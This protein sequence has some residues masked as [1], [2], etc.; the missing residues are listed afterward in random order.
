MF[1]AT[2]L[3]AGLRNP[4]HLSAKL[5]LNL[6][7]TGLIGLVA[8]ILFTWQIVSER[9]EVLEQR[10][11]KTNIARLEMLLEGQEHSLQARALGWS[12]W[13][14]A[15]DHIIDGNQAFV[16]EN[17]RVASLVNLHANSVSI[18]RFDGSLNN[19]R[20]V[21]LD[22]STG[23]IAKTA[24]L[25]AYVGSPQVRARARQEAK[26]QTFAR[27]GDK[28]V[29]LAFS[30]VLKIDA[31]DPAAGF[32]VIGQEIELHH[33]SEQ[34]Q[35]RSTYDFHVI[36]GANNVEIHDRMIKIAVSVADIAGK[37]LATFRFK[38]LR[39]VDAA[40]DDLLIIVGLGIAVL[41]LVMAWTLSWLL[42]QIVVK[43][44]VGI[45]KHVRQIG[46]SKELALLPPDDRRDEI[47]T[48]QGGFNAMA[49]QLMELRSELEAQSFELGKNQSA[50]GVMHNVRNGLSPLFTIISRLHEH[51]HF[52]EQENVRCA[53]AE[54]G[55]DQLAVH[56]R[57]KLANFLAAA[58]EYY[59]HQLDA[60]RTNTREAGRSLSSVL[61]AMEQVQTG[62]RASPEITD[63]D[64]S[65]LVA[66]SLFTV[67]HADGPPIEVEQLGEDP[68]HVVRAN[69]VLLSQIIVNL[70]TNATE[71]IAA[72]GRAEGKIVIAQSIIDGLDGP[73]LRVAFTDN[74]EGFK[75]ADATKLFE[76]GYSTRAGKTGGLGLHWCANTL[77]ATGGA[78]AMQSGG[79]GQG[80][81]A[82]LTLPLSTTG[83]G[84]ALA[85]DPLEAE[86]SAETPTCRNRRH[87]DH[88]SQT[89]PPRHSPPN[90]E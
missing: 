25:R 4:K 43:P 44:L 3:W 31:K 84:E 16:D 28:L 53:L 17:F 32:A 80:A 54:L 58:I 78:L 36:S 70:L 23:D 30:H 75:S 2:A 82:V 39:V 62:Q 13:D 85:I 52:A 57:K 79:A 76:R 11:V 34:L 77:N 15:Y 73:M 10:E 86:W 64:I 63:C 29:L 51:L 21:D 20:Y 24:A 35:Q 37:P 46:S 40:G 71:A 14:D 42:R 5:A 27:F 8:I 9:F 74:G 38:M 87:R 26:F 56:R 60:G 59:K 1:G 12:T 81:T 72:S 66:S 6:A 55:Q 45:E 48:L 61:E 50:I 19:S 83:E 18:V 7:L 47:G 68:M 49:E 88:I 69:R 65:A 41:L 89:I 67:R 90:H 33:I 22:S